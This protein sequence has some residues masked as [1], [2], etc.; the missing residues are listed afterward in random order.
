MTPISGNVPFSRLFTNKTDRKITIHVFG[1]ACQVQLCNT[2]STANPTRRIGNSTSNHSLYVN[3]PFMPIF[4]TLTAA[5]RLDY[6]CIQDSWSFPA[7]TNKRLP[8]NMRSGE[9]KSCPHSHQSN[10][11]VLQVLANRNSRL[12]RTYATQK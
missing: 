12:L 9:A 3:Y 10:Q 4:V 6:E 7:S 1:D 2:L 11:P 5:S 8:A